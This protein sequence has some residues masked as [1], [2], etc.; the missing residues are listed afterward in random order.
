MKDLTVGK[1]S[2]LILKFAVPML[3]A[4]LFQQLYVI[5]DRI[6]IGNSHIGDAG[7][8][9][10][11]NAFPIIFTLI[12]LIIGVSMGFN[13]VISQYFGAKQFDKVKL[14]VDTIL[15]FL[16][17]ASVIISVLG[18]SFSSLIFK[19]VGLAP[20]I[21]PDAEAYTD[22]YFLGII[23]FFGFHGISAIL[24]GLGDSTTP[25]IFMIISTILNIFFDW[26]FI[27]VF[28]WGIEWAAIAT[29]I[30]QGSVFIA[31]MIYLNKTHKII[32]FS[33][34]RLRFDKQIFKQSM[35]IG[36][37]SGFQSTFVGLGMI[38]IMG[39]VNPFGQDVIAAFTIAGSVDSLA[40][41][42]A[43][44]FS[45][46]LTTFVGQNL[47]ANKLERVKKGM[48]TTLLM[49]SIISITVTMIVIFF[50]NSIMDLFTD[51]QNIINIGHNYLI[52]VSSFYLIF[53]TMFVIAGVLRGAGDTLIPMFITLFSL[54]IIRLPL[55]YFLSKTE[56]GIDGIWWAIPI[57]WF[58]GLAFSFTY[59]KTG[60]WK[61]KVI[62][63]KFHV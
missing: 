9:A 42:P 33:F 43:M 47:G 54:W 38:A 15:V 21:I 48:L 53:T 19:W 35:R 12:S 7:N 32:R 10:L 60:R 29:I 26:L 37:P 2:S 36:L 3:L 27:I 40:A 22:V 6:I 20:E 25:L 51:N 49:T 5:V 28:E 56:L 57:A 14:A 34:S 41:M 31:A 58:I 8:A 39:I 44:N 16:L 24:R 46:A 61:N 50:G 17:I 11:G 55:A 23:A 52:I 18:F 63:K 30:A 59:Y 1:E 4:N 45:M 13:I 62:I